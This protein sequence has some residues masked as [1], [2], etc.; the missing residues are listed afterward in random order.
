M[1][2]KIEDYIASLPPE[3]IELLNEYIRVMIDATKE[4]ADRAWRFLEIANAK[5]YDLDGLRLIVAAS[6]G[7]RDAIGIIAATLDEA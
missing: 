3:R 1:N 6:H 4:E 5:G 7:N 2:K